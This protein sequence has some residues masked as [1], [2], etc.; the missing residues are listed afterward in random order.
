MNYQFEP[1][2]EETRKQ[3]FSALG[4]LEKSDNYKTGLLLIMNQDSSGYK[5]KASFLHRV[6]LTPSSANI[7]ITQI[8]SEERM[9]VID[10]IFQTH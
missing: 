2:S 7:L 6:Y 8:S 3:L 4:L 1:A 5:F 10:G 9:I